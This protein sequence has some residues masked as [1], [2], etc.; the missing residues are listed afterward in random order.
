MSTSSPCV[1]QV[2]H[3]INEAV[4]GLNFCPFA[5][6]EVLAKSIFYQV[7]QADNIAMAT[8]SLLDTLLKLENNVNLSTALIIFE[9][10]FSEF[11]DYLDLLDACEILLARG[12]YEGIFQLASFHPE[13]CFEGIAEDDP[14]NYTNR[15]PYPIV[16]VLREQQL[17]AALA[18]YED[19][20]S[21][22]ENNIATTQKLGS[23]YFKRLLMECFSRG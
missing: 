12:G 21:I 3:W 16:H 4:V 8:D 13:Y 15:A 20:A 19:P 22:P 23:E 5:K 6:Q 11:D 14:Q 1:K 17:T 2:Q 10:S 9:Q 7:S 18:R